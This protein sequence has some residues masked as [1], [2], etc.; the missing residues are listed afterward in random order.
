MSA[1]SPPPTALLVVDVQNDFCPGG[2]LAVPEGDAVVPVISRLARRATAASVPVFAS[3]DW[4]P[5]STSHFETGGGPWPEH[6][7]AG[8]AG[9]EFHP[10]LELPPA[11]MVVSKGNDPGADGYSAFD[12]RLEDGRSLAEALAAH[13]VTRLVVAGLAT[14]YCVRASVLD[15]CRMGYDVVVVSDAIRGVEV[16][17]GDSARA[18]REMRAAG[19]LILKGEDVG[20]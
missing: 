13:G 2:A 11:T 14:D 18:L 10:Q 3:R 8:T 7:V 19:A 1:E 15:A 4:H 12:G 20:F 16:Q 9:A 17:P 5:T 6:C